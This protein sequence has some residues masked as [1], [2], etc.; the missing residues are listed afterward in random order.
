MKNILVATSACLMLAACGEADSTTKA[1]TA[2]A[3]KQ[4]EITTEALVTHIKTLASDEFGGR[5]PGTKGEELTVQYLTKVF[6]DAGLKPANGDSYT[7]AVPLVSIETLGAPTLSITGGKSDLEFAYRKDMVVWSRQLQESAAV[8]DSELVFVGYGINAPERGW[9]DYE[10]V[11]VTG[12]TVVML[13]N[14]PGFATQDPKVF[15]G[16]AMTYYGR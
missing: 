5:A 6:K 10:G 8:E 12:K 2:A 13:I 16:N 1:D 3:V 14:D 11:D 7:Q 15:N 9:N 4:Y